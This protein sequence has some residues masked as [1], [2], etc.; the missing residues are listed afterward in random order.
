MYKARVCARNREKLETL[1]EDLGNR[2]KK[3]PEYRKSWYYI[4][5]LKVFCADQMHNWKKGTSA[6]EE[7]K[8]ALAYYWDA[9]ALEEG[10]NSFHRFKM[11]YFEMVYANRSEDLE[12]GRKTLEKLTHALEISNEKPNPDVRI[13]Q[14]EWIQYHEQAL[15]WAFLMDDRKSVLDLVGKLLSYP[16]RRGDMSLK[17]LGSIQRAYQESEHPDIDKHLLWDSI[18]Y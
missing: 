1:A 11:V 9:V 14:A 8:E 18:W 15:Y 13:Q 17:T 12:L 2:I 3:L 5:F 4:S 10:E 16:Y 6:P 7:L